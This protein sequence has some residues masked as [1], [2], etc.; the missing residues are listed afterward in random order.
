L[1]KTVVLTEEGVVLQS[2]CYGLRIA[3]KANTTA[4]T[5]DTTAANTAAASTGR[6]DH[7]V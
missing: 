7:N 1:G 3:E 5:A 4:N 6:V 2:S